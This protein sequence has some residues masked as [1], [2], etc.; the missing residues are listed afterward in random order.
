MKKN[1]G[2]VDRVFRVIVAAVIA[3]LYFTGTLTGTLG[4][5]LLVLA[6]VFV[7]TSLVS[8]CPLYSLVGLNT[9]AVKGKA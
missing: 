8:F 1:M 5:V 6:G 4:L 3:A 7:A 2:T 9:C